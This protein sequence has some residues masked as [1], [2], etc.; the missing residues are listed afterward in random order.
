MII[1]I[2]LTTFSTVLLA[3]MGDKTQLAT[4]ALSGTT[5]R[6]FAVFIGSASALVLASLIGVIAGGTLATVIP[7][8]SLKSLAAL[9][10]VLIGVKLLWP[11]RKKE[12]DLN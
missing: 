9:G 8:N 6:P 5:H 11:L 1:T 7:S 10:F 4:I 12:N 3:E 2:F